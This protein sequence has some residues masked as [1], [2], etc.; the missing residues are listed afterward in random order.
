MSLAVVKA[1]IKCEYCEKT[2]AG[3]NGL[4]AHLESVHV[5]LVHRYLEC[6]AVFT[7]RSNL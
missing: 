3:R 6:E 7:D 1:R 4:Q 2:L 5:Q